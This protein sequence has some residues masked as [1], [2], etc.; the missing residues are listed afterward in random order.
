MF[1]DNLQ[2]T[3]D[4]LDLVEEERQRTLQNAD[5]TVAS[6]ARIERGERK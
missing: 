2:D 4:L 3:T 5:L 6:V 1:E